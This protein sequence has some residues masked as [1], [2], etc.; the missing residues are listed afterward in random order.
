MLRFA[1]GKMSSRKGNIITGESLLDDV[2]AMVSEKVK[3]RDYPEQEKKEIAERVGV[4]AIKYSIL[5]QSIGKDIIFDPEKSLSFEGDSGPYLQYTYVRAR[6]VLEKAQKEGV[7]GDAKA[8]SS[9]NELPLERV[10][11]RFTHVVERAARDYA[12]QYI[13]TYLIELAGAFNAYY[14]K[15]K[16]V[17]PKDEGSAYRVALTEAVK[18]TLKNGLYLLGMQSPTRM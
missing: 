13:A 1:S 6:A 5:K 12:P 11:Y 14:A 7:K 17:D 18:W 2:E 16:I 9:D 10:V 8:P 3:D 4:A 15:N